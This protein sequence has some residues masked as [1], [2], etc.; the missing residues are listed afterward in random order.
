MFLVLYFKR[1]KYLIV[2]SERSVLDVWSVNNISYRWYLLS[3]VFEVLRDFLNVVIILNDKLFLIFSCLIL[4]AKYVYML[5]KLVYINDQYHLSKLFQCLLVAR[6]HESLFN[7]FPMHHLPKHFHFQSVKLVP[8]VAYNL[9]CF[10]PTQTQI[11]HILLSW[12][13]YL[14]MAPARHKSVIRYKNGISFTVLFRSNQ[15][16]ISL[17]PYPL[18]LNNTEKT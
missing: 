2:N 14:W 5:M 17:Y 6:R 16:V 12:N 11:I 10:P 7:F 4:T 15:P 3:L 9:S 13:R 1:T 8:Y 18:G